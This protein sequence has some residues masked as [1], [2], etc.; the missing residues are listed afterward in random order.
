MQLELRELQKNVGITFVFVTHDQEEA[1]TMADRI[2]I[3]SNGKVLETGAP[4]DLYERPRT[5]F[6]AEFLGT[7]NFLKG[8]VKD[9]Q[10]DIYTVETDRLGAMR[11]HHTFHDFSV[12]EK[13]TV[14]LRPENI[15]ISSDTTGDPGGSAQGVIRN[16]AYLGDRM[17]IYVRV[18]G[19]E[20]PILVA[21]QNLDGT[22]SGNRQDGSAI[23]FWW[24][25]TS[26]LLL[27]NS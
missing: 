26:T 19:A 6:V 21:A 4:S 25:E 12:G 10:G 11:V 8:E 22:L 9:R 16:T 7:M 1:L 20:Q 13:L 2:A 15:R 27:K 23:T 24:P 17:H 3:M 14:G 18:N 5:Q